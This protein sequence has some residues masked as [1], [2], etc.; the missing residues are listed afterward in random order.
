MQF[1]TLALDC[2]FAALLGIAGLAKMDDP[3]PFATTLR[4]QRL[5][6]AWSVSVM[7]RLLPWCEILLAA[8]LVIGVAPVLVAA[9]VFLLFAGFLAAQALLLLTKS[10]GGCGCY[11]A[12]SAH[13]VEAASVATASLLLFLAALHLWLVIEATAI[14]W[15]WR[16]AAGILGVMAGSWLGWR[17]WQRQRSARCL[18]RPARMP[19][20]AWI[21]SRRGS[22]PISSEERWEQGVA[23]EHAG[24]E[25]RAQ[26]RQA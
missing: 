20:H 24:A 11:G 16:L 14:A 13:R 3:A 23:P 26:R 7:R 4:R 5:L 25:K 22:H 8:V 9:L 17:T 21:R 2:Y 1:L 12:A 19:L 10:D 18:Q 6:P 15:H